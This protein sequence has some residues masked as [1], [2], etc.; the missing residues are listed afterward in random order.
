M[1]KRSMRYGILSTAVF[2]AA[3]S[4]FN[5]KDGSEAASQ[6]VPAPP[7]IDKTDPLWNSYPAAVENTAFSLL[8]L[9]E[10][11]AAFGKGRWEFP[12]G[13]ASS[14]AFIGPRRYSLEDRRAVVLSSTVDESLDPATA[15]YGMPSARWVSDHQISSGPIAFTDAVVVGTA[16]PSLVVLDPLTLAPKAVLPLAHLPL[17]AMEYDAA[18]GFLRVPHGDGTAGLYGAPSA[19]AEA[20]DPVAAAVGPDKAALDAIAAESVRRFSLSPDDGGEAPVVHPYG[21]R[22]A[23]P[24]AGAALFRYDSAGTD[25]L[26]LYVDGAEGRPYGILIFDREGRFLATNVEYAA[27]EVLEFYP[28]AGTAYYIAVSF[29]D[30]ADAAAEGSAA[31]RL[32]IAA[33]SP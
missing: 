5:S 17:G 15:V 21:P 31:P 8:S 2:F 7:P 20:E 27:S 19:G 13:S 29:L 1:I 26:R 28:E 23:V 14:A 6:T 30:A 22:G 18:A 33:K 10:Q 32:I 16:A 11:D 3:C 12:E 9:E 4:F 25:P 24:A